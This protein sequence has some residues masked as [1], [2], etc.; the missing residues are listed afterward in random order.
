MTPQETHELVKAE[1]HRL[2]PVVF[3]GMSTSIASAAKRAKGLDH[4]ECPHLRPLIVRTELRRY[5][6]REGLPDDWTIGGNPALMGQIN[7]VNK[8]AG[9]QLRVLKERSRTYPGG[10]PTAGRS[11]KRQE[12]WTAPLFL[13]PGGRSGRLSELLLLWDY[14]SVQK[15][16]EGFTI[17]VVH[18]TES[19]DYGRKVRCDMDFAIMPGGTVFETLVF[20]GDEDPVNFFDAE[21][22]E[23]EDDADA[24]G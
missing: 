11:P 13:M 21:I 23:V 18:P 24:D 17:R 6:K 10:V 5:L 20:Q 1:V 3:E 8:Q 14:A 22:D 7:L 4:S 2:G 12:Y 9:L 16:A 15:V 19:G